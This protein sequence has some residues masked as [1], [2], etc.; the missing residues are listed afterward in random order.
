MNLH[1]GLNMERK[2]IADNKEY[3]ATVTMKVTARS[4]DEAEYIIRHTRP[5]RL[6]CKIDSIID[7]N[8]PNLVGTT[9][10]KE[11]AYSGG[12]Q[13]FTSLYWNK[14]NKTGDLFKWQRM[15]THEWQEIKRRF[16]TTMRGEELLDCSVAEVWQLQDN[17][18]FCWVK[19]YKSPIPL[20]Y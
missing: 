9:P 17:P 20:S 15:A 8:K 16:C 18:M 6:Q 7:E 1:E 2:R 4:R 3:T 19:M 12:T 13:I 10:T 11:L 5:D 14:E